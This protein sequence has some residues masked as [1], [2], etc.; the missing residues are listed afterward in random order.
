[1]SLSLVHIQGEAKK[2]MQSEIEQV[3]A[4]EEE[5]KKVVADSEVFVRAPDLGLDPDE[6]NFLNDLEG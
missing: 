6:L 3:E 1:M 4:N 2:L 5:E